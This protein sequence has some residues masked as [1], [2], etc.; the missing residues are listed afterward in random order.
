[1]SL[2]VGGPLGFLGDGGLF[3]LVEHGLVEGA[4]GLDL[5]GEHIEVNSELVEF[6][7]RGLLLVQGLV[8]GLFGSLGALLARLERL[9]HLQHGVGKGHAPLLDLAHRLD[10]FGVFLLIA[11]AQVRQVAAELVDGRLDFDDFRIVGHDR[12]DHEGLDIGAQGLHLSEFAFDLDA[13]RL[14][15]RNPRA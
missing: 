4:V 8:Q 2:D 7:R 14:G 5:A 1:M 12:E 13:G 11:L 10:V 9:G 3:H 15:F 6:D